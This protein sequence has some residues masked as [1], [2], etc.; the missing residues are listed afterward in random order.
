MPITKLK[1]EIKVR[2]KV[3]LKLNFILIMR[4]M[5]NF[6]VNAKVTVNIDVKFKIRF[7]VKVHD[8]VKI[9]ISGPMLPVILVLIKKYVPSS[10]YNM[11]SILD[12]I[13]KWSNSN[14]VSINKSKSNYIIF[15]RCQSSFVSRLLI[16]NNKLDKVKAIRLVGLWISKDLS[17]QLNCQ[18]MSKNAFSRISLHS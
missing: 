13:S 15:S 10:E 5:L 8:L 7:K 12:N 9:M 14:K 16:S 1:G 17:W 11:Q 3:E 2:V 4:V 6:E 18:E